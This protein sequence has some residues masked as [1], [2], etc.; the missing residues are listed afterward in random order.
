MKALVLAAGFGTRLKPFTGTF[1]KPL[2]PVNGV[3]LILYTLAFLKTN[4]VRDVVMN[5][6]HLGS[7]IPSLLGNGRDLGMRISYSREPVILGT[8]GGIKKVMRGVKDDLVVINGDV[9]ADFD[10]KGLIAQHRRSGDVMT[11]ALYDHPRAEKYGL[12]S[13]EEERLTS[14]LGNPSPSP[15]AKSAMYASYHVVN[16]DATRERFKAF[17]PD[18]KFCIIRD[19]YIPHIVAGGRF[20]AYELRGFWAVCDGLD[21]VR[22]AETALARPRFALSY[23]KTLDAMA[24]KLKRRPV[25]QRILAARRDAD[26]LVS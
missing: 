26:G 10:L 17:S 12:I 4:G 23:A 15:K 9:I 2:V 13:Y 5:L 3:P 14:L 24:K 21:D 25:Y 8:G 19:V 20:G 7:K 22:A 11:M 16:K 1:P 6:H 18:A